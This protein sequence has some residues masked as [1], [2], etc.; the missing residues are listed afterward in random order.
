MGCV[1]QRL[2]RSPELATNEDIARRFVDECRRTPDDPTSDIETIEGC[3]QMRWWRRRGAADRDQ[4]A[5]RL[6]DAT[7][8]GN[9]PF[10]I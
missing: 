9:R 1:T 7:R 2:P 10:V 6:S 4:I 3:V 5:G 8:T